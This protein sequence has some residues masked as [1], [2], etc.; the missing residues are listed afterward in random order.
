MS[1]NLPHPLPAD[2]RAIAGR[3]LD[4][5]E[6]T[7]ERTADTALEAVRFI[8][9]ASA[10]WKQGATDLQLKALEIAENNAQACL[11]YWRGLLSVSAPAEFQEF[12]YGFLG[13]QSAAFLRQSFELGHL[14]LRLA[15]D[16]PQSFAGLKSSSFSA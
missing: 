13:D 8:D 11:R 12:N 9:L 7:L 10:G 3:S 4:A 15:V 6:A 5:A 2:M 14:A 16:I 1:I